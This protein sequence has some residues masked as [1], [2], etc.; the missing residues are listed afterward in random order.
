MKQLIWPTFLSDGKPRL[1]IDNLMKFLDKI[2]NPQDHIP[3]VFHIAGTNGKGSTTAFIK[4]ILEAEGYKVH[5]FIS[6]HLVDINERIEVSS[7]IISDDYLNDLSKE[8]KILDEKYEGNVS[9]FEGQL[10]MA[11]LAFA[12]NPA[13]AVILEVGLGGR[14]DATNVI[15]NPLVDVITSLSLDHTKILGDTLDKIAFEKA[16]IIKNGANVILGKQ[17]NNSIY[18]FFEVVAEF[19]KNKLYEYDRDWSIKEQKKGFDFIGFDKNLHLSNPSLYGKHQF[20]NV[21]NAIASVLCQDKIYVSD[22]SIKKGIENAKWLGRLQLIQNT[23][24]NEILPKNFQLWL[25]GAHNEGAGV[26]IN[27]WL[28]TENKKEK[29]PTYII[30]GM[31]SRKNSYDFIL[32]LK[33]RIDC[34]YA[35]NIHDGSDETKDSKKLYEELQEC[36]VKKAFCEESFVNALRTIAKN[37]KNEKARI[38]IC[39]SLHLVGEVLEYI[40]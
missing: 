16:G 20:L 10:V 23:N 15:K 30:I 26:I 12:R 21:G 9:Y 39:G 22:N 5:R 11:L 6:P 3:P 31:L 33:D 13:D 34:F 27:D 24:L 25:D 40:K 17:E 4:S 7:K 8:C 29:M 1:G 36:G 32:K 38:L 37:S 19:R 18:K 14:L 28:D 2:D 35:I